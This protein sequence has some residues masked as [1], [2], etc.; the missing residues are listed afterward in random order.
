MLLLGMVFDRKNIFVLGSP[1][2]KTLR[3]RLFESMLPIMFV[4]KPV[5]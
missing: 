5:V 4:K 1:P 2:Q 3:L